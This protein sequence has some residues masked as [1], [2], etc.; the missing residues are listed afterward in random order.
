MKLIEKNITKTIT[1]TTN[2]LTWENVEERILTEKLTYS[3][4]DKITLVRTLTEDSENI[5]LRHTEKMMPVYGK[6]KEEME[7]TNPFQ[8]QVYFT[9]ELTPEDFLNFDINK[10]VLLN[11][12]SHTMYDINGKELE[13]PRRYDYMR[14]VSNKEYNLKELRDYLLSVN[15]ERIIS[16]S[17]IEDIPYYNA[18]KGRD[19]NLILYIRTKN[20][21]TFPKLESIEWL[22]TKQFKKK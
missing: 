4:T 1:S 13:I 6:T 22:D 15:D 14:G 9:S 2:F 16:V 3:V 19:K 11:Y 18:E 12:S 21:G 17:K 10:I 20:L 5:V 8:E 7:L